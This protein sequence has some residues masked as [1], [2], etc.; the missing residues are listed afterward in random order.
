MKLR[1]ED[2][3]CI[4]L[5]RLA[6]ILMHA[7]TKIL[8]RGFRLSPVQLGSWPGFPWP[9]ALSF[10]SDL[11]MTSVEGSFWWGKQ[12]FCA[13]G[14]TIGEAL[15]CPPRFC[16]VYLKIILYSEKFQICRE[17]E[18]RPPY[19]PTQLQVINILPHLL[20]TIPLLF[21]FSLKYFKA[22]ARFQIW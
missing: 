21:L 7:G 22:N 6:D 18:R 9:F 16:S 20:L 10:F 13:L 4:W 5:W 11:W 12:I 19:L 1:S 15:C 3:V 2:K 17:V 14:M 8:Q